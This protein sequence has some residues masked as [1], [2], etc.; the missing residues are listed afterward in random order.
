MP[1]VLATLIF[2]VL[3]A[4]AALVLLAALRDHSGRA[5]SEGRLRFRWQFALLPLA[6][7]GLTVVLSVFYYPQ[8]PPEVAYNFS[9]GDDRYFSRQFALGLLIGLQ[10]IL[11]MPVVVISWGVTRL[12]MGED[13]P[14]AESRLKVERALLLVT[15]LIALPQS[16]ACFALADIFS[17]NIYGMHLLPLWLFGAIVFALGTIFLVVL[18]LKTIREKEPVPPPGPDDSQDN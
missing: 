4:G 10:L 14:V 13:A 8:L 1:A 16:L 9:G 12:G 18:F 6:I 7:L 5:A 17:Y 2:V 11:L 15:N 3:F